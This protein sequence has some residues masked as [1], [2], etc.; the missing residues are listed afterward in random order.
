MVPLHITFFAY[1]LCIRVSVLLL[2]ANRRVA[3]CGKLCRYVCII[4]DAHGFYNIIVV[5]K[6]ND[7]L[8]AAEHTTSFIF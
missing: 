7:V 8:H 4:I 1:T 3:L 5:L 2:N 6:I